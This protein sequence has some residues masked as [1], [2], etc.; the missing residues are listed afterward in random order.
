MVN[1]KIR[2][3]ETPLLKQSRE[4]SNVVNTR[5]NDTKYQKKCIC[6][7]GYVRKKGSPGD[8]DIFLYIILNFYDIFPITV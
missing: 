7:C 6:E 5:I 4:I 3:L 2:G 1:N 8:I